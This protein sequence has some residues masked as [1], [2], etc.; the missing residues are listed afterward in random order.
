MATTPAKMAPTLGVLSKL[1]TYDI[2]TYPD[3]DLY[4]CDNSTLEFVTRRCF[5]NPKFV[6]M[7]PHLSHQEFRDL[8]F[9]PTDEINRSML[10][11]SAIPWMYYGMDVG[12]TQM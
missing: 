9:V 4:K 10:D 2:T 6:D 8:G 5:V 3:A 1:A 12:S 11:G 7:N